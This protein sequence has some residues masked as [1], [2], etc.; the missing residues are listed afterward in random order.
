MDR[1]SND[2]ESML[3]KFNLMLSIHPE[4][5]DSYTSVSLL[6]R[7]LTTLSPSAMGDPTNLKRISDICSGLEDLLN[8][9]F[10]GIYP[11]KIK[12]YAEKSTITLN[13]IK[14]SIRK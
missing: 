6:C 10:S 8:E 12:E 5:K 14:K 2:A 9:P 3:Q 1:L 4:L 11:S 13:N 7:G